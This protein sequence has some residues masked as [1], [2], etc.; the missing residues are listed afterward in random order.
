MNI[1]IHGPLGGVV[2]KRRHGVKIFRADRIKFVVMTHRAAS[3]QPHEHLTRC[4]CAITCVEHQI[5]FRNSS[6]FVGCDIAAIKSGG[7]ALLEG[8]VGQK[9]TC[10]L[11]DGEL[12]KR[13]I[14]VERADHPVSVRPH[15]PVVIE[16]N[17]MRIGITSHVEPIAATVLAP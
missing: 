5:L 12:V 11:F 8:R 1:A 3:G 2:E 15:F 17:A 4:F 10:Q 6:A 16:M 14:P 13:H 9:V 7:N